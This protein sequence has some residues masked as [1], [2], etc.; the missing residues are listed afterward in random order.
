VKTLLS[1]SLLCALAACGS[2][3]TQASKDSQPTITAVTPDHGSVT[4]G[5]QVML[6]GTNFGSPGEFGTT[7][8][9]VGGH[10]ATDVNVVSDTQLSF[11]APA[12]DLEGEV[13]EIT[14]SNGNGF[15]TKDAAFTFNY[16]PVIL[17]ITPT[18]GKGAGGTMVT[19][20]GRGFMTGDTPTVTLAGGTATNV[21][22]VDDRTITATSGAVPMN[23][24]A[25]TPLDV[26]VENA[27][28]AATLPSVFQV[29]RQGLIVLERRA[30]NRIYHVDSTG[31]VAQIS[32]ATRALHGCALSPVNGKIYAGS[33]N[34]TT[35][36]S[37]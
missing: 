34:T 16:K 20:T 29:T 18:I 31:N 10:V 35:G 23:T 25:F 7:L 3:E 6:T 11:K 12:G 30:N 33:F 2:V 22:V 28:G 8:V 19:I 17:S 26:V 27:N 36:Q 37:E 32:M 21:T 5:T 4:G 15:G 1:C 13:V 14:V 24:K 9:L